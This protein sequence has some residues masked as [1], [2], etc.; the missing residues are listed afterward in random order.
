[1]MMSSSVCVFAIPTQT[2][3]WGDKR[4]IFCMRPIDT[5]FWSQTK[6]FERP[7][8][9]QQIVGTFYVSNI[10][11]LRVAKANANANSRRG[12]DRTHASYAAAHRS[13]IT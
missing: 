6:V 2:P 9:L 4:E 5:N 1:M 10:R 13:N 3:D 12:R 7:D 8:L 11:A